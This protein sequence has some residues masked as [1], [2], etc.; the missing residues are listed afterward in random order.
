MQ[1]PL[2]HGKSQNE[3]TSAVGYLGKEITVETNHAGLA[4]DGTVSWE[5]ILEASTS[6]TAI[7]IKDE[8]GFVVDTIGGQLS[9]GTHQFV[10]NAPDN[11]DSETYS[12]EIEAIS[13]NGEAVSHTIY[14]KGI[15]TS[16]EKVGGEVL[17]ASN[18][19]L[20]APSNVLAVKQIKQE[21]LPAEN[22]TE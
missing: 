4:D 11:A 14:S 18:G 22:G 16:V 13:G 10:W 6:S 7:T 17:L 21:P 1:I 3:T 8:N 2:F 19:I 20:T 9:A 5:Y 15:V 12:I